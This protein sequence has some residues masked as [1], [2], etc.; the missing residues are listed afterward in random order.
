MQAVLVSPPTLKSKYDIVPLCFGSLS[1]KICQHREG[2]WN[3]NRYLV[4]W[5][6]FT[7]I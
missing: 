2:R 4:S 3:L 5:D 6:V 7:L 1:Q